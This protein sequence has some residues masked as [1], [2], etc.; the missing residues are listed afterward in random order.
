MADEKLCGEEECPHGMLAP[1]LRLT[2]RPVWSIEVARGESFGD[3]GGSYLSNAGV[4]RT[5]DAVNLVTL[6]PDRGAKG[7][8]QICTRYYY[9]H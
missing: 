9:L 5:S 4:L 7:D 3:H 2:V 1:S 8:P 6:D